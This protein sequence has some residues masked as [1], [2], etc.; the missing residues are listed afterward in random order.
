MFKVIG[1][2]AQ[3]EHL[4]L[5]HRFPGSGCVGEHAG[6][7][8]Y[9]GEPAPVF[10]ALMCSIVKFICHSKLFR[11][12][13]PSS[14]LATQLKTG[15]ISVSYFESKNGALRLENVVFWDGNVDTTTAW[16]G[17]AWSMGGGDYSCC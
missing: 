5:C 15:R 17:P 13:Y 3:G 6:Q 10:F 16:C 7:L 12:F 9:L 11:R 8:R 14:V 1:Q 2:H 4:G